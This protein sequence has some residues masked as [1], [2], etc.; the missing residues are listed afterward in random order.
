MLDVPLVQLLEPMFFE[1]HPEEFETEIVVPTDS[2]MYFPWGETQRRLAEAE[3]QANGHAAEIALGDPALA[4][5]A[6]SMIRL[7][8]GQGTAARKVMANSVLGVVE[9]AGFT[10]ADGERLEW[11]RGDVIVV[12]AWHQHAHRSDYGAV[13]FRVT[14]EPVMSKLG[15]LRE[16]DGA[17]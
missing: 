2:A 9:G 11:R 3:G 7:R 12:P 1:P 17:N 6:L 4:T 10:E 15:F 8:P 5:M 16:G 14:D 13:L